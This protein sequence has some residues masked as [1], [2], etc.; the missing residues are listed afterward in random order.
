M[1]DG[2]MPPTH[3]GVSVLE[4]ELVRLRRKLSGRPVFLVDYPPHGRRP[5]EPLAEPLTVT[6]VT[7]PSAT[8]SR[9][10][11]RYATARMTAQ[12]IMMMKGASNVSDK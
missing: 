12:M 10:S 9:R 7:A 3:G 2:P 11:D 6:A 1:Y 5:A 8:G 4:Q